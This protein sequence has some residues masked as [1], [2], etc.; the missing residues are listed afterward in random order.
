MSYQK[1]ETGS[2]LE[3]IK[4]RFEGKLVT[5]ARSAAG[6]WL[7][8]VLE[9]VRQGE[10]VL[11]LTV[12]PEMTNPFGMIHGGMMALVMDEAIGWAI[13]SLDAEE[14]YT[15]V[16]LNVDFLYAI[17]EGERLRAHASVVRQGKKIIH[18]QV[19]VYNMEGRLLGKAASNLVTTGMK[20]R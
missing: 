11:S 15:S 16:N 8:F 18:A 2:V 13:V 4:E 1:I 19:S 6:N 14:H 20:V 5:E 17:R 12:R 7:Q 3:Y 9:E 10:A